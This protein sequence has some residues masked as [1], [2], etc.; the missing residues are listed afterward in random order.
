MQ[1]ENYAEAM[2]YI[3]FNP[4]AREFYS[5]VIYNTKRG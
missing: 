1:F 5:D 4:T 2:A 3:D